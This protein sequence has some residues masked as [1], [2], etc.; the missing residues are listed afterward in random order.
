MF[1][2]TE[3]QKMIRE[4]VRKL[5]VEKLEPKAAE[6]DRIGKFPYDIMKILGDNGILQ[7]P[8]PEEYGGINAD[9][10]TLCI[11]SEELARYC[12]TSSTLV[13]IQGSN[14]KVISLGG[15]EEQKERLFSAL[16][17][18]DKITAFSL[19]EPGAG[20]DVGS[21]KTTAVR[22]GDNYILNGTKCFASCG[23]VADIIPLFALTDPDKR[24]KGGISA[25]I[26]EKDTPGFSLGKS[27]EK[28]GAKGVPASELILEDARIPKEN[29]LGEEGKGLET[30]LGA[31]NLTRLTVGSQ[32]IGIAQGALDYAVEYAKQRVQ[33]GRPIAKFQGIQFK[34]A[35]MAMQL[36]A[37]RS[38]MYRTAFLSDK[39]ASGVEGLSSMAK[40]Y[41]SEVGV[42]VSM[43]AIKVLGGYGYMKDYPVERRLRDVMS[44]LFME[45]TGEIQRLN[46]ARF[47]LKKS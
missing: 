38:L 8:L 29:L 44:S 18:G 23:E 12:T 5:G 45:G 6:V 14:V 42:N 28:M 35:D 41:A 25:F 13:C 2:F 22:D 19:T 30:A 1:G 40:C 7:L 21:M 10:T 15:N 26:L 4:T 39:G 17:K 43:D 9:N 3:E 16:S 33:F 46:I 37:S 36:E 27:E 47:L 32:A 31:I 24:L 11:V 34:L 20:S